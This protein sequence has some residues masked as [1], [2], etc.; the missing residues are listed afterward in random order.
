MQILNP[1]AMSAEALTALFTTAL[2]ITGFVLVMMLLI[3]YLNVLS[4]GKRREKLARHVWGQYLLAGLLGLAPGCLGAFTAVAWKP[5]SCSCRQSARNTLLEQK[6][7]EAIQAPSPCLPFV[8]RSGRNVEVAVG[9]A[10]SDE[11]FLMFL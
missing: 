11:L 3:E 1:I 10:G 6:A 4:A 7:G 5:E 2:M 9:D 8:R